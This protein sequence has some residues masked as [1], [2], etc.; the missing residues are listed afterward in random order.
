MKLKSLASVV[1][2]LTLA[3]AATAIRPEQAAAIEL[4][5]ATPVEV[6]DLASSAMSNLGAGYS[7]NVIHYSNVAAGV[8]ALVTATAFGTN[9]S[10]R[11]HIPN[12]TAAGNSTGDA[13][14]L[15]QIDSGTGLGGLTYKIDLFESGSNYT[16]AYTA[17]DLKFLVY[18]VDG[19]TPQGEAVRVFNSDG[20]YGYQV[21]ST[22]QALIPTQDTTSYLFSGRDVN[23]AEN[24]ASG[25]AILYF[26]NTNSVTF[27]FEANTRTDTG[28]NPVFSAI[29]GDLSLI[30]RTH[31]LSPDS[32]K[33]AVNPPQF[34]NLLQLSAPSWVVQQ[35]CG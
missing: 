23:T 35:Q 6:T 28:A 1:S 29:D 3:V 22:A 26:A 11:G 2:L 7:G 4:T 24:D 20:F 10:L 21:G 15:Y 32:S 19:E 31:Q 9:Y 5:F 33:L 34:L 16:T 14:F 25:S 18:D 30:H 12:Y 27:Q 17:T 8:D 13:S